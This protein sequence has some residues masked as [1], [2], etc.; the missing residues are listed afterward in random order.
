MDKY[1]VYAHLNPITKDI[2]YIGL[3]KGNRAWNKWTGRN[4]FWDNYIN[5]HGFEVEIISENLTRKQAEKIEIEFIST[6][7]RRQIDEGG[8]LVNRSSGGDGC[9]GYTHS[10]EFKLKMSNDRK[11]KC[12]RKVTQHSQET[13][14]K[15]SKGLQGRE[16]TWGKT[17]LQYTKQEEFIKEYPSIASAETST[18]TRGIWEAITNYK[19]KKTAGGF[20]WKFK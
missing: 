12:T 18:G 6:L 2:F 8:I 15:I 5:K 14:D 3:G 20:I 7:G 19:N 4:K 16:V 11:G 9:T 13:K 17:V 1:Y 10:E